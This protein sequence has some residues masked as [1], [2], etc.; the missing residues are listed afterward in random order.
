MS[1]GAVGA[2]YILAHFSSSS[3][4]SLCGRRRS[5][6]WPSSL[7]LACYYCFYLGSLVY[8]LVLNTFKTR[9]AQGDGRAWRHD[10]HTTWKRTKSP[11]VPRR[12]RCWRAARRQQPPPPHRVVPHLGSRVLRAG[13]DRELR[14]AFHQRLRGR[15]QAARRTTACCARKAEIEAT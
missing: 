7:L 2:L 3:S 14:A 9:R 11:A 5:T 4:S 10:L 8:F 13:A 1:C 12:C 6:S 15:R